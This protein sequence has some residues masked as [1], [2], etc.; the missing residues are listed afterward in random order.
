MFT[1]DETAFSKSSRFSL[2]QKIRGYEIPMILSAISVV[3]MEMYER[4]M[5]V[6]VGW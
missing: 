3:V 1:K 2:L 6:M 5:D 4:E